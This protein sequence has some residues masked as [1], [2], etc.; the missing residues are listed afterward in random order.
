MQPQKLGAPLIEDKIRESHI[1]STDNQFA[2]SHACSFPPIHP[3]SLAQKIGGYTWNKQRKS[4]SLVRLVLVCFYA[5]SDQITKQQGKFSQFLQISNVLNWG[6][7]KSNHGLSITF[8]SI[9]KKEPILQWFF[10]HIIINI[11]QLQVDL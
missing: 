7:T 9:V 4:R 6:I 11:I 3:L 5:F 10:N 1:R 8:S 2:S